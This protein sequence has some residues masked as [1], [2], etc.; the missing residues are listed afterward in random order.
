M[1][2]IETKGGPEGWVSAYIVQYSQDNK[3]WNPILDRKTTNE[4]L[5]LG[6]F[7]SNSPQINHFELPINARLIKLVPKKWYENIQM[8]VEIHGCYESYRKYKLLDKKRITILF[9]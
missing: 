7:D 2:G 3:I 8:R 4:K 9:F 5:Y 1:T 6:N